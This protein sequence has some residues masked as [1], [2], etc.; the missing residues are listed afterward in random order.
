MNFAECVRL[1]LSFPYRNFQSLSRGSALSVPIRKTPDFR[2][3]HSAFH[4]TWLGFCSPFR[5]RIPY[6]PCQVRQ[7]FR[8]KL[9]HPCCPC[10]A[11]QFPHSFVLLILLWQCRDFARPLGCAFPIALAGRALA[12]KGGCCCLRNSF[13]FYLFF[14][15]W[16]QASCRK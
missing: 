10:R 7:G 3:A 15:H 5:L 13:V 6:C 1:R 14:L 11:G 12:R 16:K 4:V 9:R 8:R 2:Q